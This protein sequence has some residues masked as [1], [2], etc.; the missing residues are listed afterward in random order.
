[1]KPWIAATAALALAACS[2]PAETPTEPTTP[3]PAIEVPSG[4]YTL[5]PHHST[6]TVRALHFGLSHY[7]LR[8]NNVTGTLN[9][10]A[11]APAQ[12]S[13]EATVATTSLD[14]PYSGDRDFD[15][16]LQNSSWLDSAGFPTATFRSTSVEVTGGNTGRVTGD[17]TIK[18]VTHPITF[19]VTFNASHRQHPMG[20]QISLLGFSGRGT[21][22]RSQFGV[23][24]LMASAGGSDGVSDEV[25]ILIEA[26]FTRPVESTLPTTPAPTEPVN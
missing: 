13:V 24:E 19:D 12:S 1:M 2:P 11:E 20:P 18:G 8:F 9:F 26:E 17:I 21:I 10:N 6:V 25:E 16:E 7:T 3:A 22:T 14:T 23:N 15:A 4:A 5:D